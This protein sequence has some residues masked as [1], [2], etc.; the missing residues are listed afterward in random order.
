MTET[1]APELPERSGIAKIA[2]SVGKIRRTM[3]ELPS[4]SD[5][6]GWVAGNLMMLLNGRLF[7]HSFRPGNWKKEMIRA[8][9]ADA[10]Q[11]CAAHEQLS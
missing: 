10:R 6:T 4:Y 5:A 1:E 11:H 2:E 9:K 8:K 7:S 3:P